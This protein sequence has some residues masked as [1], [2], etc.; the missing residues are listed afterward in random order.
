MSK[1]RII[2]SEGRELLPHE[3]AYT[4]AMAKLLAKESG[5]EIEWIKN[6]LIKTFPAG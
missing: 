6:I 4:D 5:I 1:K 2:T 3:I